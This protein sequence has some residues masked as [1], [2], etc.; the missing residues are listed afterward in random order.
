MTKIILIRHG[1]T[2]WNTGD[3]FRGRIDIGLSE[4]GLKQ[5]S[6]LGEYL[7]NVKVDA[8]YSSPLKRAL[9]TAEEINRYHNL[10]IETTDGLIDYNF[11]EWQGMSRQDIKT[12]YT[13]LYNE[14]NT[15]PERVKTPGGETLNDVR[16]RALGFINDILDRYKGTIILVSHRV[17][18]KVIVCALLE[19][20]NSHYWNIELDTCG[21]TTFTFENNRFTL[22]R[23]NDTSFMKSGY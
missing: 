1:E 2:E 21:I 11:G 19:L 7:K 16:D 6:A 8:I 13:E 10:E 18:L 9:A 22:I 17:V 14:W 23:H 5:A 3:V 4:T 12:K 20:D 15:H